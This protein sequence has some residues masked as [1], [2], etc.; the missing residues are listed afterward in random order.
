LRRKRSVC[1]NASTKTRLTFNGAG[2]FSEYDRSGRNFHFG[3][4]EHVM[5]AILNGLSLSKVRAYGS[6]QLII[7]L[8]KNNALGVI[9]LGRMG[10]NIVRRLLQNKHECGVFSRTPEK[11][12]QLAPEGAIAALL[13]GCHPPAPIR[14]LWS[15][16]S[17]I[18]SEIPD[19]RSP[20]SG[21]C[22][23]MYQCLNGVD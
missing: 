4:R 18:C 17:R 20:R 6:M 5:A 14:V 22:P 10:A 7:T 2:G 19:R 8:E 13:S 23:M 9:G 11:V 3:V 12:K 1:L 15:I 16:S 21:T